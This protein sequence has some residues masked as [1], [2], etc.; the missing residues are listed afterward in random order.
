M[1]R[2]L[3]VFS[4]VMLALAA[5][6]CEP[7]VADAP[8]DIRVGHDVCVHC[9]MII[10][11]VRHAAASLVR[12]EGRRQAFLFDDIGDMLDY[13]RADTSVP[14]ERQYVHDHQTKEWIELSQA[15]VVHAPEVHTP[16]GSG[17]LAF[18][19]R[20]SA[21]AAAKEHAGRV[22]T[23]AEIAAWPLVESSAPGTPCC[24]SKPG[25]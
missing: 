17:I 22:L 16:M 5:T 2:G 6:G 24:E 18:S 20:E 4:T 19:A 25:K 9:N 21:I 23:P 3:A 11:D 10:S 7:E 15:H 12:V 14:T 8:P 13:H 1:M